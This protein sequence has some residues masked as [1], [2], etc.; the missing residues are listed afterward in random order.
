M[1]ERFSKA[2]PGSVNQITNKAIAYTFTVGVVVAL[3]VGLASSFIPANVLPYLTSLLVLAGIVV[4]FFNIHRD[5]AK[6]YVVLVTALVIVTSL[7][8][9]IL[10]GVQVIG[11]TLESV[12]SSILAFVL[13]SVVIV[14]VRAI[15]NLERS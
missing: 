12:L 4:G 7:S 8:E 15:L 13:P 11:P 6:D 1:A 2:M 3:V 5:E 9:N 14:A 10:S